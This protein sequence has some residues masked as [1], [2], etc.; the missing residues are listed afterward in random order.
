MIAFLKCKEMLS[1]KKNFFKIVLYSVGINAV[2]V[3]VYLLFYTFKVEMPDN[4][5]YA[6]FIAEGD[7]T[8][9]YMDFFI[10]AGIGLL[11]KLIYPINAF[12]IAHF[13]FSFF[14]FCVILIVFIDKLNYSI[15]T[16]V[17]L[18]I[19]SFFAISHY[20][21]LSFTRDA[22]LFCIAGFLL[23]QH[24]YN[25]SHYLAA[26]IIGVLLVFVG[27][28]YR[29]LV[30]IVCA[31]MFAIF[32]IMDSLAMM[33]TGSIKTK[34]IKGTKILFERKRFIALI[35][36]MGICVAMHF[37]SIAVN[38]STP[39]L[40]YYR[41][42]TYA[43]Q[44]VYDY[45]I[46]DYIECS[47]EYDRIGF[48][49]NDIDMN[50][51]WYL[52]DGGAFTLDNL[53]ELKVIRDNYSAKNKNFAS[54]LSLMITEEL[55]NAKALGDKGVALLGYIPIVLIYLI[56]M[57]KR[58]Y[59]IP[60]IFSLTI[61]GFYL[62]LWNTD[63]NPPFR[64]VYMLWLFSYVFLLYS[65]RGDRIKEVWKKR[66]TNFKMWILVVSVAMLSMVG[67]YLSTVANFG[68]SV[69]GKNDYS[70]FGIQRDNGDEKRIF[71]FNNTYYKYTNTMRHMKEFGT[72]NMYMN[73]LNENV[74]F[75][76]DAEYDDSEM[77]RRYLTKY[78]GA[79]SEIDCQKKEEI[80]GN[81]FLSDYL[82]QYNT[83][84]FELSRK[85]SLTSNAS[86]IVYKYNVHG[87]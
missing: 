66:R 63:R 71:D 73:L 37:A 58:Y 34:M 72:N 47:K 29:F 85:L 51:S 55:S 6:Q 21:N 11:Q 64:A 10:S 1:M 15:G 45:P 16:I 35:V 3:L 30:F 19:I 36:L 8:F 33:N 54:L 78:Y 69:Y 18:V 70:V 41:E 26:S 86:F 80:N 32:V 9:D 27:S 31:F 59:Y 61:F 4:L 44:A 83:E 87:I 62:Y 5:A 57:K 75:I 77:M 40:A 14:S 25:K 43:R 68:T 12:V 28:Q 23:I 56:L 42:Y 67:F 7:Y 53:K 24:F 20:G 65:F 76:C 49:Q 74:Y 82:K 39:E 38:T 50:R 84:K 46:P 22:A 2:L 13:A 81:K 60:A 79:G 17:S 48:D 52:D